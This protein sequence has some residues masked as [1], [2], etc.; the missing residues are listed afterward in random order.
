MFVRFQSARSYAAWC[1][2]RQQRSSVHEDFHETIRL[3]GITPQCLEPCTNAQSRVCDKVQKHCL[4]TPRSWETHKKSVTT[5]K[6]QCMTSPCRLASE[7]HQIT[8]RTRGRCARELSNASGHFTHCW[9]H[10]PLYRDTNSVSTLIVESQQTHE[11]LTCT[12]Q[13]DVQS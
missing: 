6:L 2:T 9:A 12:R 11:L 13:P 1:P 4:Y 10:R 5:K 3:K 7:L 8:I